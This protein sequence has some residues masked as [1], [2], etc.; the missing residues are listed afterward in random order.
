[1]D[2]KEYLQQHPEEYTTYDEH[3]FTEEE[4]ENLSQSLRG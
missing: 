3:L 2:R 4:L 1:M